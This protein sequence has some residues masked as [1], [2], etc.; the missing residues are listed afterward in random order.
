MKVSFILHLSM[1]RLGF[2]LQRLNENEYQTMYLYG[3]TVAEGTMHD[4]NMKSNNCRFGWL[5][6]FLEICQGYPSFFG[7]F[8]VSAHVIDDQFESTAASGNKAVEAVLPFHLGLIWNF[9]MSQLFGWKH[10]YFE[11]LFSSH[12]SCESEKSFHPRQTALNPSTHA[13]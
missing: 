3:K 12:L 5:E 9:G 7:C 11:G 6:W 1:S 8:H 10:S 13:W 4:A 2:C